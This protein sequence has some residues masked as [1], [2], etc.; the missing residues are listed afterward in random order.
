MDD[1]ENSLV[2]SVAE[3]GLEIAPDLLE[4]GIDELAQNDAIDK[5][6][7]VGALVAF[8]KGAVAVRDWLFVR[9]ILSFLQNASDVDQKKRDAW[10]SKIGVDKKYQQRVG[11]ELFSI[12]NKM[13]DLRKSAIAGRL[14]AFFLEERVSY[15]DFL[16]LSEKLERLYLEDL[17]TIAGTGPFDDNEKERYQALGLYKVH[18][19]GVREEKQHMI[20]FSSSRELI[21]NNDYSILAEAIRVV[22]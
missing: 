18:Y 10:V 14:F 4:L 15:T 2:K 7:V 12:I 5:I 20:A 9:N 16:R 8:G 17:D 19:P 6:P 22:A 21:P 1:I 3:P 13:N 11:D